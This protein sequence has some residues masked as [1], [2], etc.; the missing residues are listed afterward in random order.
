MLLIVSAGRNASADQLEVSFSTKATS[1]GAKYAPRNIVAVW[2]EDSNGNFV[3]TLLRYANKRV[4]YL[5]AW[6]AVATDGS[7]IATM[8]DVITGATRSS[9]G[10]RSVMWDFTDL[11]GM[12][13]PDGSYTVRMELTDHNA[14]SA[15]SNNEGQVSFEKNGNS[16]EQTGMSSGNFDNISVFYAAGAVDPGGNTPGDCSTVLECIPNDG[17]CTPDC[18]FEVDS[19]CDPATARAASGGCNASGGA[20][21]ASALVIF[22]P[23]LLLAY[24]SHRRGGARKSALRADSVV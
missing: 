12:E 19:D 22:L 13:V 3:R 23:L 17:C 7:R 11:N 15:S 4:K 8:P 24:E 10:T 16:G 9:H 1:P 14:S 20:S 21:G 5:R 18:V 2:V 6:N